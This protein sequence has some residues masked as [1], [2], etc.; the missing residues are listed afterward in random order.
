MNRLVSVSVN[1]LLSF[2]VSCTILKKLSF[3]TDF[4]VI[5]LITSEGPL[6]IFYNISKHF[7]RRVSAY[8]CYDNIVL[9][10]IS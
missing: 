5:L 4:Y 9:V 6:A 2:I 8:S 7:S 10:S 1:G 3:I